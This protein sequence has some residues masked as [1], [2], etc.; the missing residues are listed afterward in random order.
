MAT[1]PGQ[2][3]EQDD[4]ARAEARAR[5]RAAMA[6]DSA[7]QVCFSWLFLRQRKLTN[8]LMI[9]VGVYEQPC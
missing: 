5:R 7:L 3:S 8:H 1:K 6:K 9:D 4:K 2:A